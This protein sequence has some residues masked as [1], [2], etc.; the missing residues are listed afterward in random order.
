MSFNNYKHEFKHVLAKRAEFLLQ[1]P[2]ETPYVIV[3]RYMRAMFELAPM[4]SMDQVRQYLRD[5][6]SQENYLMWG[7]K[8]NRMTKTWEVVACPE[9]TEKL[10]PF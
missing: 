9:N 6:N 5:Y 2:R 7:V 4:T 1:R 10:L 8:F 3:Y